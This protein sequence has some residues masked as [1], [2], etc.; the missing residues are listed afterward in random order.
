MGASRDIRGHNGALNG[1][2]VYWKG[3]GDGDELGVTDS[4]LDD[5]FFVH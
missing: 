3:K 4:P 5:W 2:S 1:H